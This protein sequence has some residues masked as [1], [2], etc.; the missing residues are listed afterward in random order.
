M[1]LSSATPI[2][3]QDR[4]DVEAGAARRAPD[5]P[6]CDVANVHPPLTAP[7]S[8]RWGSLS[9]AWATVG[10]LCTR[11]QNH[12]CNAALYPD[13]DNLAGPELPD[14][15]ARS[16]LCEGPGVRAADGRL[17]GPG[18]PRREGAARGAASACPAATVILSGEG[19]LAEEEEDH[20]AEFLGVS[21]RCPASK[22][23]RILER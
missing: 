2:D 1:S 4:L 17:R 5:S 18:R 7:P 13:R 20:E 12:S 9:R 21:W 3:A 11:W 19:E 22:E 14:S 23:G 10:H 15:R 16:E 6:R 8:S